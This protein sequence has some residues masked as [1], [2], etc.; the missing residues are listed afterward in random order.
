MPSGKGF[1]LKHPENRDR[2]FELVA[3]EFVNGLRGHRPIIVTVFVKANVAP[4]NYP[5][6]KII[7]A[8]PI[9]F[10]EITVKVYEAIMPS[11]QRR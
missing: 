6:I 2:L 7:K 3:E 11:G 10:A 4:G 1:S 5:R 9:R 8:F